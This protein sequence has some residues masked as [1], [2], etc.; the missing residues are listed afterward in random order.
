MGEMAMRTI[1]RSVWT[2]ENCKHRNTAPRKRC[3]DC[4]TSRH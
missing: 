3:T 1:E 4:G 2:C